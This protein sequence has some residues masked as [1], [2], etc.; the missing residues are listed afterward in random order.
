MMRF[1][2]RVAVV[3]GI[4]ASAGIVNV[5][6]WAQDAYPTKPV[7]LI[8]P[9]P[10]GGTTDTMCRLIAQKLAAAFG[11][12][13]IVD[14]RGG[15]AGTIGHDLAMKSPPDGYTL[16]LTT[17]GALVINPYLYK[18]LP[19]D[20]LHDFALIS[21]VIS[22][23]P[24]LVVHPSVPARNMKELVALA[25]SRP[26][27]LNYGS[28][29]IGTTAHISG[30]FLQ[31][32][33]GTR[34]LHVPYKGGAM[35]LI[36]L[37]GGQTDLQFGDMV[38]SV[39]MIRAGKVR[40]LAVTTPQRSKALPETPTMGESGVKEAFP[41]Q[42][43]GVAAPKGTPRPI[44]DRINAELG[45]IAKASDVLARFDD[46]GVFPEHTTPEKML[47]MVKAE[48]PAMGKLLQA[49]GVDAQ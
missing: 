43:W 44:V 33:T 11:R 42:W 6:A 17:K 8:A 16:V 45:K 28:G 27:Q 39:P 34:L 38:P 23:G 9:F 14:N 2:V 1:A 24:V 3:L 4:A 47:E 30:E 41:T 48:G 37:V 46:L 21:V 40:A 18:K 32:I 15:A 26:G 35:A 5:A 19:Y 36:D 25:K 12:Q 49:A 22:A 7:R 20:P 10:P 31:R 29:G 13:V